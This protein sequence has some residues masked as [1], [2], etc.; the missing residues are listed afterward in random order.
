METILLIEDDADIR[1]LLAELLQFRGY[2]VAAVANG[3]EALDRLE[4]DVLPCLIIL[5]L[6]LPVI[7][8]WEFRRRQLSDPR[9]S[10]I[11]TVLL[12]SANNLSEQLQRLQA[13]AFI[14]K[15]IDFQLLYETIDRYC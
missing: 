6:M 10:T 5:D 2:Q 4:A 14:P 12:S 15:P 11:P 9:W 8:G 3:R 1:E 13:V 7:S